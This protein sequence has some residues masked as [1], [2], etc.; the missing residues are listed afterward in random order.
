MVCG[1]A[2]HAFSFFAE[3]ANELVL[4]LVRAALP[5][6]VGVAVVD[7]GKLLH[8]LGGGK[9][10]AIVAGY[11]L[12]QF[13]EVLAELLPKLPQ[14]AQHLA[15]RLAFQYADDPEAGLSLRKHQQ[16]AARPGAGADD[17]IHLPEA[18]ILAGLDLG[19]AFVNAAVIPVGFCRALFSLLLLHV[20]PPDR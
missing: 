11:S 3:A 20:V 17:S 18:D 13:A 14:D 6:A 12:E 5:A 8:L 19:R 2:G 4:V 10:A 16:A 9:L 15:G 7:R 1:D